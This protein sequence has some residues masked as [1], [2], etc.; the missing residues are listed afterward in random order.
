[1]KR[2]KKGQGLNTKSIVITIIGCTVYFL[3]FAGM[4]ACWGNDWTL[5]PWGLNL[6]ELNQAFKEK[7]NTGQIKEDK[8]RSEIEF[9]FAPAKSFK[10]RKGKVV[11]W[12]SSTDPSRPARLYGYAYEGKIFGRVIFFKDYPEIF[13]ETVAKNLKEK[14]PQ[15]KVFR[16]FGATRA[17]PFFE[18]KSDQ[19]YVFST[20]RG[21][22]FY[23]PH[24]LETVL[25]IEQGL[26]DQEEQRL[27][28][29]LRDQGGKP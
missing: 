26:F 23:E 2:G 8:D 28:Q 6:E 21:V 22:F 18:F 19:L 13:P 7:Y 29:K 17:I 15:G 10:V 27:D 25:R 9:H 24:V 14:Y 3:G 1:M 16:N 5:L 20:E 4:T 11:A 12:L